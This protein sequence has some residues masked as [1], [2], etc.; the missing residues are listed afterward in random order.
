[1]IAE[2]RYYTPREVAERLRKDVDTVRDG[3]RHGLRGGTAR[4]AAVRGGGTC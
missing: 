1:M 4:L 3:I 2:E